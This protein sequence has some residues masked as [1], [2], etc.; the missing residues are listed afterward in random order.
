MSN[1]N[2]PDFFYD[3]VLKGMRMMAE[4]RAALKGLD[5]A[6]KS[7]SFSIPTRKPN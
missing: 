5:I 7:G 4:S 6:S 2:I 3:T 1:I